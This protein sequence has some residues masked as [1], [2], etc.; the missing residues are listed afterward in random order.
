MKIFAAINKYLISVIIQ[1]SQN[2][3]MIQTNQ[4]LEKT[5]IKPEVLHLKKLFD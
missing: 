5:K 2:T 1:L 3:I 4:L